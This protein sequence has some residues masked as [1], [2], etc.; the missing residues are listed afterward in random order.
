M[1]TL[2]PQGNRV[3][4]KRLDED[5]LTS[6]V[7]EVVHLDETRESQYA[8]V[9]AVGP[10]VVEVKPKNVI[11]TKKYCGTPLSLELVADQPKEQCYLVM[12]EDIFGKFV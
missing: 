5:R 7:I 10:R 1:Q 6:S 3:L 12:E 9:L 11:I 8:V 2:H 4:I